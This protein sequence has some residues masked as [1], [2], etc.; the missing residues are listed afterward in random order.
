MSILASRQQTPAPPRSAIIPLQ[1]LK[2]HCA[3]CNVRESCF[4]VGLDADAIQQLDQV[5]RS[6]TRVRKRDTLYRSGEPF[7]SLYAVRLGTFKTVVLAED[8]REQIT[9]YHIAGDVLGLDGIGDGRH[10]CQAMALEDSEVCFLHFGQFN[11]LTHRVPRL[12]RNLYRLIAKEV[13]RAQDMMFMLGSTRA[14]E[15][16]ASFL[17]NLAQRYQARGYSSSEFMLRMTREETASYLGLKLE[18]VSRL[19]SRFQEVGLVQIQGRMIKLL[20]P[21]ALKQLIGHKDCRA[22][23]GPGTGPG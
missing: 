21:H 14:E 15:R 9:G 20:D 12:Q 11:E 17:L 8:G 5:V 1:D 3:S 18:T 7:G 22:A 23:D 6:R 10:S 13:C 16:L 4:P 2:T 19:F